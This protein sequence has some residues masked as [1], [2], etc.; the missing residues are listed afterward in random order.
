MARESRV[1]ESRGHTS[2]VALDTAPGVPA[3]DVFRFDPTGASSLP[4]P[5]AHSFLG[6]GFFEADGGVLRSSGREWRL[7]AGDALVIA[8]G[9]VYDVA[10]LADAC[11]W[12]A[13]FRPDVLGPRGTGPLLSWRSHPLPVRVYNR[14]ESATSTSRCAF[15]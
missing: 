1:T 4:P 3:I 10:G 13:F 7:R 6:V 2:V 11:G 14:G 8:P 9:E 15:R 12:A 5:H